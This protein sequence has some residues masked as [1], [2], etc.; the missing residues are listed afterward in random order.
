MDRRTAQLRR[1]GLAT[2]LTLVA[3]GYAKAQGYRQIVTAPRRTNVASRGANARVGFRPREDAVQSVHRPNIRYAAIRKL[4]Q[5][6]EG[7]PAWRFA[8]GAIGILG[9]LRAALG[10]AALR[11][12]EG[13][14]EL[15]S[16]LRFVAA[17][18]V[19]FLL[20]QRRQT[21]AWSAAIQGA[22]IGVASQV[23][24]LLLMLPF[25]PSTLPSGESVA[26]G[27]IAAI[28]IQGI[29]AALRAAGGWSHLAFPLQE[30][31]SPT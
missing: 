9:L 30:T 24:A 27:T 14:F 1:Q 23:L 5:H 21:D 2:A 3:A 29:G 28:A 31:Q 17:I 6:L 15:F 25:M 4:L 19:L 13:A 7:L 22:I 18:G 10:D 16:I 11:Q 20:V 8:A 12:N 26:F